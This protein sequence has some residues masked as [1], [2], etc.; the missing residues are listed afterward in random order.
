[1]DYTL[2]TTAANFDADVTASSWTTDIKAAVTAAKALADLTQASA[3]TVDVAAGV[4]GWCV[5]RI[6]P[7]NPGA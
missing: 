7:F 1:M 2:N 6:A 3:T 5:V 4:G